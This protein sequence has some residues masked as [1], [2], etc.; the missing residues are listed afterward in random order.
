MVK[1]SVSSISW[2]S[3]CHSKYLKLYHTSISGLFQQLIGRDIMRFCHFKRFSVWII[4][5]AWKSGRW[6]GYSD[7]KT[8]IKF[9]WES[10]KHQFSGWKTSWDFVRCQSEIE[11]AVW[12][13]SE[14]SGG[15]LT[16]C[17]LVMPYG[18]SQGPKSS[19]ALSVICSIVLKKPG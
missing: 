14:I 10:A 5:I 12:L 7:A 19:I 1:I 6:S 2:Y 18:T 16:Y 3:C 9:D 15:P 4:Y 13:S 11:I 8:A 17:N